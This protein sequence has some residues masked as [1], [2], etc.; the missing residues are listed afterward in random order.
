[1][2]SMGTTTTT[3]SASSDVPDEQFDDF[4]ASLQANFNNHAGKPLFRTTAIDLYSL[5]RASLPED[6]RK[7]YDCS[8]CRNFVNKYGNLVTID[9]DGKQNPVLWNDANAPSF[10]GEA[11]RD[12]RNFVAKARVTGVYLS[13]EESWGLP[14]NRDRARGLVWTHMSVARPKG[15]VFRHATMDPGQAMAERVADHELALRV[16]DDYPQPTVMETLRL[17]VGNHLSRPGAHLEMAKWL[18]SLHEAV[19]NKTHS[20]KHNVVWLAVATAPPGY[21]HI[22]SGILGTLLD[23]VK[24]NLPFPDIK[25]KWDEKMDPLAY[26]RTQAA[27]SRGNIEEAEKIVAKL[28]ISA[29]LKRRFAR[30]ED[31]KTIW[32]PKQPTQT[33]AANGAGVFSHLRAKE[34]APQQGEIQQPAT[35]ITWEK[36]RRTVLPDAESIEMLAPWRGGYTA[37]ITAVDPTAPPIL[38]WDDAE[39]RNPVSWYVYSGGSQAENWG[40][41]SSTYVRVTAISMN[42]PMW[43]DEDKFK[44]VP[45]AVNFILE[46]ARESQSGHG[47]FTES[48]RSEFHAIRSTLEAYYISYQPEGREE[49]TACGLRFQDQASGSLTARVRSKLGVTQYNIDRWD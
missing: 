30:L 4:R 17:L 26:R 47:L 21:T 3:T 31:L 28:G 13:K 39:N 36:F 6:R 34:D 33:E 5:L 29:S 23:D 37:L 10:F 49:A 19:A 12:L 35:T 9:A 20:A 43:Q 41:Q 32:L 24:A 46:G 1:M 18:S 14:Q 38:Q 45:K 42:P 8:A 2:K 11:V 40:L 25:R 7:H 16:L 27:P 44:H 22:R 15:S 48:L